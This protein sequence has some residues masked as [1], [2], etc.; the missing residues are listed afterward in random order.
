MGGGMNWSSYFQT[1]TTDFPLVNDKYKLPSSLLNWTPARPCPPAFGGCTITAL[2]CNW[3]N[4]NQISPTE[5][6]ILLQCSGIGSMG[7][8]VFW[9]GAWHGHGKIFFSKHLSSIFHVFVCKPNPVSELLWNIKHYLYFS[10]VKLSTY[11]QKSLTLSW[12][13]KKCV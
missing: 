2:S 9:Y 12:M 5:H 10:C 6:L 3:F 4:S 1:D 7:R 8:R 13:F 11:L